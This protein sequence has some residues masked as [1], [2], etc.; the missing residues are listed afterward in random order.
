MNVYFTM[1]FYRSLV[2]AAVLRERRERG[3]QPLPA[4]RHRLPVGPLHG[5]HH[6]PRTSAGAASLTHAQLTRAEVSSDVSLMTSRGGA[7]IHTSF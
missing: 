2:R 4:A 7:L 6:E 3:L 1:Y 5:A